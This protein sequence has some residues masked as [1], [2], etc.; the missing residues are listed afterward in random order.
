MYKLGSY[1]IHLNV[2]VQSLKVLKCKTSARIISHMRI[3]CTCTVVKHACDCHVNTC[4]VSTTKV[5]SQLLLTLLD[6]CRVN[7]QMAC[8]L[9]HYC[10]ATKH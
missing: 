8:I 1:S 7:S 4:I 3:M 5:H 6:S 2:V 10:A 9:G